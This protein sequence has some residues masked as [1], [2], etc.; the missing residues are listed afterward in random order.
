M[1]GL[2]YAFYR[3]DWFEFWKFISDVNIILILGSAI[4]M[5][6]SV[7]IRAVRW[8]F[9]IVPEQNIKVYSLF[10]SCMIGYF[11]NSV[12]PFRLGELLRGFALRTYSDLPMATIIGTIVLERVLDMVSLSFFIM[13]FLFLFPLAEWTGWFIYAIMG[14]TFLVFLLILNLENEN[15]A[16]SK[17]LMAAS[18][19]SRPIVQKLARIITGI[20]EGLTGFRN[21]PHGFLILVT[22]I[23]L[24][25]MY[26]VSMGMIV[27]AMNLSIGWIGA[28]ILLIATTVSILIPAAPGYIGTYHAV[29]VFVLMNLFDIGKVESQ[30]FA[31]LAH[32]VGF[33]PFVIFGAIY[34][35]NSSVKFTFV[36]KSEISS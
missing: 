5:M 20:L 34:F 15:V 4:I 1:A 32:A 3:I 17:V 30:G 16:A 9:L 26:Y 31:I 24:W 14:L 28:G 6:T 19:S 23:L 2:I 29:T 13:I 33:I 8:R 7:Y 12:L 22:T 21:S 18:N 36:E 10:K 35:I 27:I 11:G 25:G